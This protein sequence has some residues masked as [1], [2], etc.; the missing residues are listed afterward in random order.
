MLKQDLIINES[1]NNIK[2]SKKDCKDILSVICCI[3][4]IMI[5]YTSFYLHLIN[6]EIYNNTLNLY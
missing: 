4:I 1:N 3:V 6:E 2:C 5:L